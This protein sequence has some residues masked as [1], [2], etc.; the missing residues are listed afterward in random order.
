MSNCDGLLMSMA[1]DKS[2]C[3]E[4]IVCYKLRVKDR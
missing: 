2:R 4:I 1:A 3:E